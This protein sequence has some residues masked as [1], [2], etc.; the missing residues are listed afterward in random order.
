ME[1]VHYAE[2]LVNKVVNLELTDVTPRRKKE[3]HKSFE[4]CLVEQLRFLIGEEATLN[5]NGCR[6]DHPSQRQ[7]DCIMMFPE[8]QTDMF[9]YRAVEKMDQFDVMEKWYPKLE[10]MDLDDEEILE[11]YNLWKTIKDKTLLKEDETWLDYWSDK[12]KE[13][14][15]KPWTQ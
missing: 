14:Q 3:I 1:G 6:I 11:A 15:K 9:M 2:I 5:C 4:Q 8:D 13:Y 12:V 10:V 7:H